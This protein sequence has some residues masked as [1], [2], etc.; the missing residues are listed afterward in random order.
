M[1]YTV[2]HVL[3]PHRIQGALIASV[4]TELPT[5]D[6][7]TEIHL[8]RVDPGGAPTIPSL[9][10]GG[11]LSHVIGQSLRVHTT[12][13]YSD[14]CRGGTPKE[15]RQLLDEAQPCPVCHPGF[16][17]ISPRTSQ[18]DLPAEMARVRR[19]REGRTDMVRAEVERHQVHPAV[20]AEEI[21]A[22]LTEGIKTTVPGEDAIREAAD[23]DPAIRAVL[24]SRG[25]L[26]EAV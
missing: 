10:N 17:W 8:Y 20:T 6:R 1:E 5:K 11:Y 15:V 13:V 16:A 12:A 23:R 22:G 19:A 25:V 18:E 4:T 21:I 24:V 7:W 9:V 14:Q 26:D 3:K 2:R